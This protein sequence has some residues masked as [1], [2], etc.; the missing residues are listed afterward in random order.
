MFFTAFSLFRRLARRGHAMPCAVAMVA[1]LLGVGLLNAR[2]EDDVSNPSKQIIG[3]TATV[4]EVSTGIPFSARVDTGA[5]TC[6]LHVENIRIEDESPKRL[7]NIGKK[8]RFDVQGENGKTDQIETTIAA[9]VR[10]KS[11]VFKNGEYDRRYKVRLTLQWKDVQKSVL[12]TINDRTEMTYPL[13]IGRNFLRG[14]FLVDVEK[15][16]DE[17]WPGGSETER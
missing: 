14:D 9:A 16:S 2:G 7:R 3:G 8:V 12:V 4:V 13:L 1:A 6:S 5:K 17:E 10:V 11:S 15:K